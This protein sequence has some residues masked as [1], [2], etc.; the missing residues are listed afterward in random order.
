MQPQIF[1]NKTFDFTDTLVL[2]LQTRQRTT[3]GGDTLIKAKSMKEVD[4]QLIP[5]LFVRM[6]WYF[7]KSQSHLKNSGHVKKLWY[8]LNQAVVISNDRY[9]WFILINYKYEQ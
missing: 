6:G 1:H 3:L 4:L 9:T 5:V 8:Y 2:Y 7:F